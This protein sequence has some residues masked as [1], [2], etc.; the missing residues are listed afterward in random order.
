MKCR[1]VT[2]YSVTVTC[3]SVTLACLGVGM[4]LGIHLGLGSGYAVTCAVAE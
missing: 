2:L 4:M 3:K 1:V